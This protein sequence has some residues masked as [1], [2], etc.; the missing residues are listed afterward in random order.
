MRERIFSNIGLK[1][2][3]VILAISL[4]FFV[5]YRGQSEMVIDAPIEFKNMPAGMELLKQSIKKVSLNIMGHESILN[6]LRPM[7]I[8]VSVDLSNGKKGEATYYF[9]KNHV[10]IPGTVKVL[11]LEPSYVKVTLD[12]S[13]SKVISVKAYIIGEPEKGYKIT[14]IHVKPSSVEVEGA[15]TELEKVAL[16]RTEPLDITGL[17]SD[18]VQNVRLNT[19][20]RNIRMKISEVKVE[21]HI[22]RF[23][24]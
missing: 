15:K 18:I 22:N 10:I 23:E 12:E 13:V 4:W 6:R 3:S 19:N 20:G 7:D 5:A 9:D 21:V 8:K 17:D 1:V 24:K 11:R 2:L 14:A 16:L